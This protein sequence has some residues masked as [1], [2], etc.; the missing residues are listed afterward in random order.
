[1]GLMMLMPIV[2]FVVSVM[3]LPA[4]LLVVVVVLMS[5][6]VLIYAVMC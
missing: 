1:M 6:S 2:M 4:V 5:M 3:G